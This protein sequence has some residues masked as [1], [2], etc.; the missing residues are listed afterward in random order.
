MHYEFLRIHNMN[1]IFS[2]GKAFFA[3]ILWN[4]SDELFFESV[5]DEHMQAR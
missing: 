2:E 5:L 1:T 4:F 3:N